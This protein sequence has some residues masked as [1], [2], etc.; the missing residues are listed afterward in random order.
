MNRK[1]LYKIGAIFVSLI[2]CLTALCACGDKDEPQNNE[3]QT[4]MPEEKGDTT[5]SKFDADENGKAADGFTVPTSTPTPVADSAAGLSAGSDS[6]SNTS[7][8]EKISKSAL[9][10]A[11]SFFEAGMYEDAE[12][13][14][15]SVDPSLLTEEERSTYALISDSLSNRSGAQGGGEREFSAEDAIAAAEDRY[16]VTIDGDP[17]GLT[18][19]TDQSG[20]QYYTMQVRI[21]SENRILTINVYSD[22]I[23]DELKEE[24]IAYG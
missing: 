3:I 19:Q 17:A 7:E 2:L 23:I 15:A 21:E 14:L 10:D 18:P 4:K 20:R 12:E 11:R 5:V 16:G 8:A 13:M 24:P 1:R 9:S 6:N 22:G